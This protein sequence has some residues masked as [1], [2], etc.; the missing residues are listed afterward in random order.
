M[1][2]Y[3]QDSKQ[4]DQSWIFLSKIFGSISLVA[5]LVFAFSHGALVDRLGHEYPTTFILAVWVVGMLSYHQDA[6][7]HDPWWSI[8]SQTLSIVCL[9]AIVVFG[10]THRLWLNFLI[11]PSL[12]W[13]HFQ[14]TKRWWTRPG[15]WW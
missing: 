12:A 3:N 7:R 4:P 10:F 8:L 11:A 2:N 13:L 14:F 1:F 9:I 15:T 6:K 5:I